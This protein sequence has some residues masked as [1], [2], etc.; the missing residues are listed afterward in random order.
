MRK[1][2]Q[3]VQLDDLRSG[4]VI[5]NQPWKLVI[6]TMDKP[7][8]GRDQIAG[9]LEKWFPQPERIGQFTPEPVLIDGGWCMVLQDPHPDRRVRV[10]QANSQEPAL[11]IENHRQVS[12]LALAALVCDRLVE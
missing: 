11:V 4:I 5:D 2:S 8:S 3:G 1:P 12:R 7:V 10:V 9:Q 6:F